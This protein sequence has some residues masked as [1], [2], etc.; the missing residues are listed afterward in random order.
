MAFDD[1]HGE[2]I[3]MGQ[4]PAVAASYLIVCGLFAGCATLATVS[5]K[6]E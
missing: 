5:P 1:R 2:Q 6:P 4:T 3:G